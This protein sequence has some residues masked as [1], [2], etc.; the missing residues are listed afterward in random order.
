MATPTSRNKENVN[1]LSLSPL[2]LSPAPNVHQSPH[3]TGL[4]YD[5]LIKPPSAKKVVTARSSPAVS[6][7]EKLMSAE[8]RKEFLKKEEEQ[9]MRQK[10]ERLQA[11]RCNVMASIENYKEKT[12][13]KVMKK[14]ETT[15]EIK[16]RKERE[17]EEK[18]LAREQRA[19][20]AKKIQRENIETKKKNVEDG[21]S[22]RIKLAS[23]LHEASIQAKAEKAKRD[24]M[25]VDNGLA[26]LKKKQD[27]LDKNIREDLLRKEETRLRLLSNVK[28]TCG[29]HVKEAKIRASMHVR[30]N[31]EEEDEE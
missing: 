16:M 26:A 22:K 13:A 23:E 24:L 10:E 5:V 20:E 19:Q 11:A 14:E 29:N 18:R 12:L 30:E 6:I 21:L 7:N 17:L 9:K 27:E 3:G 4:A 28:E 25:K 31:N 1:V 2:K 15:E 8:K